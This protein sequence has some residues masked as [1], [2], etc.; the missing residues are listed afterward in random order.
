MFDGEVE[1]IDLGNQDDIFRVQNA[2]EA[3]LQRRTVACTHGKM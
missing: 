1:L 3:G 2:G